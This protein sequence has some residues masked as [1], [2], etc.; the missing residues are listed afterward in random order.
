M[1]DEL[2]SYKRFLFY[3]IL[4]SYN[5]A[6]RNTYYTEYYNKLY[7]KRVDGQ[8]SIMYKVLL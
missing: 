4:L 1:R 7:G 5:C 2:L 8:L 6:K 3:I